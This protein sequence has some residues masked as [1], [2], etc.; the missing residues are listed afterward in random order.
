M[1]LFRTSAF[2]AAFVLATSLAFAQTEPA[3]SPPADRPDDEEDTRSVFAVEG[4]QLGDQT[5]AL[6][7][8]LMVPLFYQE[9]D[10]PY[11]DTNLTVGGAGE[12][13]WSAY[14][15]PRL[16][17]GLDIGGVFARTPNDRTLFLMPIVVRAAW[18]FDVSRFEFPV[19]VGAGINIVRYREWSHVDL[20]L[21][22][23]FGGYW[24]YDSNWSF[25]LNVAWWL[26]FQAATKYQD[27]DQARMANFL[28]ITPGV[29]Y[30]F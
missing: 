19:F 3:P 11:H 13:Q 8:G 7:A 4:H 12:L 5:L 1:R 14:V 28:I 10:G 26:D 24:R 20:I 22:P 2:A 18:V 6:N 16:R 9:F 17:I 15:S 29:F 27:S 30:N 21:K 23:G 25:G